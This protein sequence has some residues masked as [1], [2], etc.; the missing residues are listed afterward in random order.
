MTANNEG[1]VKTITLSKYNDLYGSN[2][3]APLY[4]VNTTSGP[5]GNVS[6]SAKD[7]L[8]QAVS[9][10]V[11]AT[12]IPID[13]TTQAT[14]ESLLTSTH[15]RRA[16]NQKQLKIIETD[17]AEHYLRTNKNAQREIA[18]LGR[19]NQQITADLVA[20]GFGSDEDEDGVGQIRLGGTRKSTVHFEGQSV[21]DNQFVNAFIE[22]AAENSEESDQN[23]EREFLNKCMTLTREDL[24]LL[25]QY[26]HRP[27]IVELIVQSI[28]DL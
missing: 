12:F 23:L 10:T 13:L 28:E 8:G 18:N 14:R 20:N 26:V 4:V 24:E 3:V 6:F 9:V 25:R 17:S 27:A 21:S 15:F 7:D 2:S 1:F 19:I 11:P 22:R 16:L 5:K